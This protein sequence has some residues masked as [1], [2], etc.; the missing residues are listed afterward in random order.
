VIGKIS[1]I[2]SLRA[3]EVYFSLLGGSYTVGKNEVH[4][5]ARQVAFFE[6]VDMFDRFFLSSSSLRLY[7]PLLE[8][9][10]YR[11]ALCDTHTLEVV[12]S[13]AEVPGQKN[14]SV[15][16]AFKKEI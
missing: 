2:V 15:E 16:N 8:E 3:L 13:G 6:F 1:D 9:P 7:S 5:N 14:M 4:R 11:G 10:F 12:S